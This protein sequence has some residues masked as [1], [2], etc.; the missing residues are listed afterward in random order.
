MATAKDARPNLREKI[1]NRLAVWLL[2][3]TLVV[4]VPLGMY[5][6]LVN[7]AEQRSLR[8]AQTLSTIIS[9]FRTYY[10]TNVAGR[11]LGAGGAPVTL[12]ENYHDTPGGV[13]IPA[14]LSIELGVA[15]AKA[16]ADDKFS[17]SFVS[18]SPFL[19]RKRPPP[20]DFQMD[21]LKA[22]RADD[23][24]ANFSRLEKS[25][26]VD[27]MRWAVPVRMLSAC[28]VCHNAH[29]DSPV[30][31]WKVGDVRGIQEVA[32]PLKSASVVET[33][34]P[35]WLSLVFLLVS[36]AVV[37][38]QFHLSNKRSS[39]AGDLARAASSRAV[40]NRSSASVTLTPAWSMLRRMPAL[41]RGWCGTAV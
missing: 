21:A 37:L 25:S 35:L 19:N 26:D 34:W 33:F 12:T 15:I 30:K 1:D 39:A 6:S 38:R 20:D 23:K 7:Q 24:R 2:A 22:F 18:D 32:V 13:P 14:T 16:A 11:I 36:G 27:R 17:M 5:Q 28:V 3:F 9:V 4:A 29:L 10:A 40:P 8:E 31:T 41:A